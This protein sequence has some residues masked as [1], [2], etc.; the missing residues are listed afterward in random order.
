VIS[1]V[2][3]G[4]LSDHCPPKK[5][6]LPALSI[7]AAA[8]IWQGLATS[9]ISFT[10]GRA[11]LYIAAGGFH[12]VLQKVLSTITPQRKRGAVFGFSSCMNSSGVM[13]AAL[14]GGYIYTCTSVSNIFLITAASQILTLPILFKLLDIATAPPRIRRKYRSL[15]RNSG[16]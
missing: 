11:L 7:S 2:L 14:L 4:W 16:K 5:L 12:P 3:S 1:G 8:L 6:L 13:L 15:R 10:I 9:L